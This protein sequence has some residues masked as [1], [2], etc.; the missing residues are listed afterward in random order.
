MS[1][2][3]PIKY[4]VD[5]REAKELARRIL[6]GISHDIPPVATATHYFK[7]YQLVWDAALF[8]CALEQAFDLFITQYN[9]SGGRNKSTDRGE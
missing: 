9:Q 4:P 1:E 2:N 6:S 5:D 8:F 3:L 7:D